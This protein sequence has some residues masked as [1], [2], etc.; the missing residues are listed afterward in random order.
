LIIKKLVKKN[1]QI[2]CFKLQQVYLHNEVMEYL[3]RNYG[4]EIGHFVK[5]FREQH[6]KSQIVKFVEQVLCAGYGAGLHDGYVEK[7]NEDIN[8]KEI[9][10]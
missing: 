3:K 9:T 8:Y 1:E 2:G 7:E 4:Q 10:R 5:L 6:T